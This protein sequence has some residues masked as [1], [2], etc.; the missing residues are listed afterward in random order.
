VIVWD[1]YVAVVPVTITKGDWISPLSASQHNPGNTV[2]VSVG[3]NVRVTVGVLVRVLV[4][5]AV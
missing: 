3:V 4:G 1:M 2:G 5:V